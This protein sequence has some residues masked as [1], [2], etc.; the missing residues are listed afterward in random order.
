MSRS[1]P[2]P[3][4]RPERITVGRVGR[5]HGLDG[6]AH[7]TGHGGAVPLEPGTAVAV[8][9]RE[10]VIAARKGTVEK[11]IVRFDIASTREAVEEL[12]GLPVTVESDALPE[13]EEDEFFHVDLV[14]CLVR[15][16]GRDLGVVVAVHQYP[17]N[18]ALEL[19]SGELIAFVDDVI[20][21]VDPP[22]RLIT[23]RE[24]AV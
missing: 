12:R 20:E 2:E 10:A 23:V 21:A 4:W 22:A 16:A 19:D 5:P 3:S 13:T 15:A 14:G 11:P 6:S 9:G 24:D 17:A 1:R 7:L 18:D 8:G